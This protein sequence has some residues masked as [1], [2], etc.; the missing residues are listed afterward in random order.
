[1]I[2]EA[3]ILMRIFIFSAIVWPISIVV[4]IRAFSRRKEGKSAVVKC[5]FSAL[6]AVAYPVLLV[7]SLL[8]SDSW[9]PTRWPIPSPTGE[10]RLEQRILDV[11]GWGYRCRTYLYADGKS[12]KISKGGIG[13]AHWIDDETFA[14]SVPLS[15]TGKA[16]SI[17]CLR[18]PPANG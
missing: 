2:D 4:F 15:E 16:V 12:Y 8:Y 6:F 18:S 9:W 7:T 3:F 11:G 10:Y 5:L 14:V 1:M 17:P 13:T